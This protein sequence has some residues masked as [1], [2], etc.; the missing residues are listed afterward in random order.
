MIGMK[1]MRREL[2]AGRPRE[3]DKRK[4]LDELCGFLASKV[5]TAHR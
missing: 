1:N 5:M 4:A 2:P 3:F